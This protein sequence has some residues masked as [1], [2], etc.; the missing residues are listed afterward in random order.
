MKIVSIVQKGSNMEHAES[1]GDNTESQDNDNEGH[2]E[3]VPSK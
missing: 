1:A 2:A 3:A